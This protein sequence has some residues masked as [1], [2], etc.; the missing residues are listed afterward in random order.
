MKRCV[1]ISLLLLLLATLVAGSRI[2]LGGQACVAYRVK[3][4][5]VGTRAGRPCLPDPFSHTFTFYHCEA[6]P[7]A[8]VSACATVSVDTP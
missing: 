8:G 6:V 4:P 1:A 5:I 3:A 7:P 2:A